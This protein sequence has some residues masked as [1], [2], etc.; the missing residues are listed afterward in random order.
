MAQENSDILKIVSR[1]VE[2]LQKSGLEL[3]AAYLY[4]SYVSGAARPDSDIDVALI[5]DAFTGD[6]LADH[7]RIA[8]A[9][10]ESDARIEVVR[11]RPETFCDEHPLAW[12]I[13]RTGVSLL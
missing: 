7:R 12:E 5:S 4:G 10:F 2:M 6:R 13:K 3:K 8:G 11:F 1:F 9:L